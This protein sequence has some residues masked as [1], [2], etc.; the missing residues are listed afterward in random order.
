MRQDFVMTEEDKKE[1]RKLKK[2]K[3]AEKLQTKYEKRRR[4]GECRK[5]MVSSM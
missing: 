5:K 4:E 1:K 2:M 3:R